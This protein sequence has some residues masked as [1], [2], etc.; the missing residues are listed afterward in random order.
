MNAMNG[1]PA[2]GMLQLSQSI[3]LMTAFVQGLLSFFSPCVLPLLPVY[4]GYMA[5]G[6]LARN[7]HGEVIWPRA[8][9]M[10]NTFFF[11]LGISA[12]LS[13]LGLTFTAAGRFLRVHRTAVNL[14]CGALVAAFGLLQLG[15]FGRRNALQRELRLP[16][17]PDRLRMNPLTALLMGFCFSFSWTP[18]VGPT[19]SGILMTAAAEATRGRGVL[20]MAGYIL[21]FTLPFLAVGM[22]TGAVLAFFRKHRNAVRWSSVVS[23]ALLVVMGVL[24]MT[25]VMGSWSSM[26]ASASAEEQPQEQAD[27]AWDFTMTDQYGQ[28]HTLS[29]YQ[30]KTVFLNFWTTWC[31]WCV[32]EMPDIQALYQ[33]LGENQGDVVFLGVGSP[34]VD[35][36]DEAGIYAFLE[37]HGWTYPV[38]M[39]TDGRVFDMYGAQSLPTTWLIRPDGNL[40]GYIPGALTK[41][42]MLDVIHQ[43][44]AAE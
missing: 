37:E 18:C 15:A 9:T 35:S 3:P 6:S 31:P 23:G 16:F 4:L 36:T 30:G 32:K 7:G 41:D 17:H 13:L 40:M 34:A 44:Q 2:A 33:E 5:G 28:I 10:V 42:Q 22:F 38:L 21:G 27:P 24:I 39:D 26:L 14:V 12:A 11:V 8:R 20:L 29:G 1:L 19:L 25:G 43:T